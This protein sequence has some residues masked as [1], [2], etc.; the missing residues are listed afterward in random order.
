SDALQKRTTNSRWSFYDVGLGA[1]GG[2]NVESDFVVALNQA[3]F[4]TGFPSPQC[5]KTITMTYNGK[6]A[7]AKIVDSCPGCPQGGLDLSR[8]LF[9]HFAAESVGII[10]GEWEY[11]SG[12]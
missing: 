2:T 6:T 7:T 9:T 10:Y 5:G 3:E 8:G 11:A 4:G 1:C 12:S